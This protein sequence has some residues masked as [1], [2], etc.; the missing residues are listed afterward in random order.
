MTARTQ[1]GR[2]T[3][4]PGCVY[5]IEGIMMKHIT[6]GGA[7]ASCYVTRS[8]RSAACRTIY[9]H[10]KRE[11]KDLS[12]ALRCVQMTVKGSCRVAGRRGRRPRQ[13]GLRI[14]VRRN[15]LHSASALWRK[16]HIRMFL[17]PLPTQ[18]FSLCGGPIRRE[19]ALAPPCLPL[20]AKAFGLCGD[21]KI[22]HITAV[23]RGGKSLPPGGGRWVGLRKS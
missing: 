12:T 19:D 22:D 16:L 5:H 17:L 20:P 2:S 9:F 3:R 6:V 14:V 1:A 21:P 10:R 15:H 11:E 7:S 23:S 4:F 8:R 18:P 13:T